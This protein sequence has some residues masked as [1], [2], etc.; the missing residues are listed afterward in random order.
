M[1]A[2]YLG[3]TIEVYIDDMLIKSLHADQHLDHIR[4]A[5][6]VLKKYSMKRNPTKCLFGVASDKFLGY[7][8]T[9]HGIE[10]SQIRS[11]R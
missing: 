6:E 9:Q 3:D 10:A 7:M 4:Q 11:N 5:F 1:F 8:V 2:D